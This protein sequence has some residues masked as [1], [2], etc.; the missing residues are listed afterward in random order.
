V[1]QAR[2]LPFQLFPN[3]TIFETLNRQPPCLLLFYSSFPAFYMFIAESFIRVRYAETDQMGYVYY[4]NYAS[5][6]EVARTEA[7]RKLGISYKSLEEQEGVMLPVLENYTKYLKPALYD[8]LLRIVVKIPERPGVRIRFEYEVYNEEN[9]LLNI[10]HTVL[11]FVKKEG[12]RPC[13]IPARMMDLLEPYYSNE[14]E[15]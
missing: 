1:W 6:Y 12:G 9:T 2:H 5:Y 15:G 4:G 8:D 7:L 10:G 13:P 11:V 14:S 3:F